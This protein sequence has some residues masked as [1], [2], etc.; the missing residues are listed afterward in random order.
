L[1]SADLNGRNT[2]LASGSGV[3]STQRQFNALG[4]IT[5]VWGNHSI[6][7]GADYRRIFPIIGL[8]QQENSSLFDGVAQTLTGNAAR[9]NFLTRSESQR[10][11]FNNVSI[12][13]QDEWRVSTRLTLNYGLRWEVSPAPSSSNQNQALAVNQVADPAQLALAAPDTRLWKTTFGNFAPRVGVAYEP[14]NNDSLVIRGNFG[15]MYD[16][17]NGPVGDAYADSF[18]ILN[19]QTQFNLPF[20]FAGATQANPTPVTVPFSAFDPRLKLPYTM[21]WTASVQKSFGS[22][23]DIEVSYVGNTGRRLLLTNTLLNQNPNFDFLRLTKNAGLSNYRSLQ[24]RFNRRLSSGLAATVSYTWAKSVD[25]FSQDSALRALFRNV[26]AELE[27]GPSDFDVRHTLTGLVSYDLPAPFASGVGNLLTRSWSIDSVFN[28]RSAAPVNV[29][30][31]VPT[32]FGFLYLRPDLIDGVPLYLNDATAA[33]GKRINP[34]AF[35]VPQNLQQGTLGRNSLRGFPL[36]QF[37]VG[38]RRRFSFNED[39]R[40]TFSAEAANVLNHPNFAAPVG[41]DASLGTRFAPSASLAVNPTFGQS[42]TNAARTPWG[43]SGSSFGSNYYPGG[44]RTV[45][46]AVQLEF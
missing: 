29:V 7:I 10:P 26:N 27:S 39:V 41:N 16:L 19:G 31:A 46:L 9:V 42:Y 40:L 3:G 12:Y 8:R 22:L 25:N 20:S 30:Y 14:L 32:S 44:A 2:Q 45:K 1:F 35:Q 6:K 24:L 4:A 34:A 38:L 15:V 28:V 43:I 21:E 37:N 5:K 33:G 17:G 11:V 23:Q 36:S 13:G 18:P